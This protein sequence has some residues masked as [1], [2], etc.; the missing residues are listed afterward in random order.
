M[1]PIARNEPQRNHLIRAKFI[2]NKL[3]Y[4]NNKIELKDVE[5]K[6]VNCGSCSILTIF[7]IGK[8]HIR[9]NITYLLL[10]RRSYKLL[11]RRNIVSI[12]I[13]K[14]RICTK[15][16]YLKNRLGIYSK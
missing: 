11:N 12:I 7:Y 9:N 14:A 13:V 5:I 3:G 4:L 8:E 2:E 15:V 16:T 10:T 1:S 6:A